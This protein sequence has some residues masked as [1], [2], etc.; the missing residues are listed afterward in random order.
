M[1]KRER[2]KVLSD[3][4]IGSVVDYWPQIRDAAARSL[5]HKVSDFLPPDPTMALALGCGY[6]GCAWQTGDKRFVVKASL[7]ATEGPNV[8]RAMKLFRKDPGIAYYHR[9]WRLPNRVMTS[10]FGNTH[11]WIM[12]REEVDFDK[13]YSR[14]KKDDPAPGYVKVYNTLNV[15]PDCCECLFWTRFGS[16]R[17][18]CAPGELKKAQE[19]LY[20]LTSGLKK[21][22]GEYVGSM[23]ENAWKKHRLLIGDVHF[24]NVGSRVHN[25]SEF[26]VK[27]HKKLVVTDLGDSGQPP[28]TT[29]Q[30]SM[31]K[32]VPGT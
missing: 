14:K 8:A 16:K 15:L 4:L 25:L 21:T 12:V 11:V 20:K 27:R 32:D 28:L 30:Y 19:D 17:G 31:P 24:D 2:N 3:K 9:L 6:W 18:E 10:D 13:Q 22:P 5:K 26:G 29:D 23:I 1:N 7:D